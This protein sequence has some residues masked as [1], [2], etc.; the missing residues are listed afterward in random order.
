VAVT[1]RV[2]DR[3][4]ERLV[5]RLRTATPESLFG[6]PLGPATL[7]NRYR[8]FARV[9]HADRYIYPADKALAHEA[10]TRLGALYHEAEA[11]LQAGIYGTS[12][13]TRAI[14]IRTKQHTYT[15]ASP[16]TAGDLS[17]IYHA[18]TETGTAVLIKVARSPRDNDLLAREA[19]TLTTLRA[20]AQ[21]TSFKLYLPD[22]IETFTTRGRDAGRAANVFV[23]T[24]GYVPLTRV[25]AQHPA[26]LDARHCVWIMN[27]LLSVLGFVHNV[28][29]VHGAV[30]PEHLLVH[31]DTHGLLLV[32]WAFAVPTG[33]T[34]VAISERYRAWYAPE[35]LRKRPATAATD[36]YMMARL[37]GWLLGRAPD[38]E[39]IPSTAPAP[40][41]R[42]LAACE[43]KAQ[44]RR[45]QDAFEL[46]ETFKTVAEAMFGKRRFLRLTVT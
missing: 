46:V 19:Q 41:R 33:Q 28:G 25:Q 24:P 7:K 37:M 27:R 30:L 38:S 14:T 43:L 22:L 31:P 45:P 2:V 42:F 32:D 20:V 1:A 39:Y 17:T 5:V 12:A 10:F 4:L 15:I 29:I 35:V 34:I 26:G 13:P 8:Q 11:R 21:T 6:V 3:D 40:F 9:A 36:L 16:L 44:R 18:T 23:A